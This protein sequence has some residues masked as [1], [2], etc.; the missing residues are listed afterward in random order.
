[1]LTAIGLK[2]DQARA[3]IRFS[4]GRFNT[5]EDI[6][7]ALRVLPAVV[8]QLRSV[9]PHYRKE[10]VSTQHQAVSKS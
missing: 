1:V 9:S 7:T 10:A 6:D 2:P 4:L 3:S 5:D 8:E